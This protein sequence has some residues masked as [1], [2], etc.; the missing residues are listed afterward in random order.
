[1]LE[2]WEIARKNRPKN[3]TLVRFPYGMHSTSCHALLL[4]VSFKTDKRAMPPKDNTCMQ[5]GYWDAVT[6]FVGQV[7]G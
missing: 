6:A 7:A 3:S 4:T 2:L 1:M 5:R